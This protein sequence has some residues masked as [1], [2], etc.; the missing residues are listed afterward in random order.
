LPYTVYRVLITIFFFLVLLPILPLILVFSRKYRYEFNQRLA[1]YPLIFP[2]A[3]Y[4]KKAVWIHAASVGEV[5]AAKALILELSNRDLNLEFIVTTMT[6]QGHKVACSQLPDHTICLLAPLDVPVFVQRALK[7]IGPD[8]YICME[9]ELWP[10][11]LHETKEFGVKMLLLNGRMSQRSF[12][13]Y[14]KF[15]SFMEELLSGFSAMGVISEKDGQR[16]RELGFENSYIQV[17]GNIK[18]DLQVE[19][20]LISRKKFRSRLGLEDETTFLCG[21]TRTGE[22]EILSRVFFRLQQ[23]STKQI[24]W[25][26]APRHIERLEE[27]ILL[28]KKLNLGFDLYSTIK[29]KER[30][31]SIILIDCMGELAELYAAGDYNFCGGSLVDKGG[32]NIMEAARFGK[33]VYFGPSMKDFHDAVEILKPVGAGFQV[34]DENA[35]ADLILSHMHNNNLYEN[36][37]RAAARI[38]AQHHG[39]ARRQADMVTQL[40]A[41]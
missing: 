27:V 41:A 16:Y 1:W 17:T 15:Q 31:H 28:F 3:D 35:L 14:S 23:E 7:R 4:K 22:E 38:A 39:A 37:C 21:S 36:A 33:P 26:V 29:N 6:Q 30:V 34:N 20:K 2:P 8:V 24:V 9:T 5:Q 13:R 12:L 40:L 19:D 11:M 10:V 18:Y 32:H 25:I